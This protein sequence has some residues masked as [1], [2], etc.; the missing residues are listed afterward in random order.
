MQD[1]F[2]KR[3]VVFNIRDD[4]NMPAL[5]NIDTGLKVPG[6][7]LMASQYAKELGRF[8]DISQDFEGGSLKCISGH[9]IPII[10]I[11]RNVIFRIKGTS[12]TFRR[13]FYICD[14]INNVVDVMFGASFIKDHFRLLFE[15]VKGFCSSCAALAFNKE[16]AEE[17]VEK[18]KL[19]IEQKRQA[20]K[21]EAA[22]RKKE[23]EDEEAKM[24]MRTQSQ[25][26]AGR[27]Q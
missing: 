2:D 22:R 21:Q 9:S 13:D 20:E 10:G 14:A 1:P 8:E 18:E 23:Q 6:G 17:K 24:A 27:R 11:L 19:N 3:E 4:V 25:A 12:V 26:A 5:A 15:K 7:L 16:S